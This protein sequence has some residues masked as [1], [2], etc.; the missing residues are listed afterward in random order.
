VQNARQVLAFRNNV[1]DLVKQ[2]DPSQLLLQ[3]F[4]REL[5]LLHLLSQIQRAFLDALLQLGMGLLQSRILC[6]NLTQHVIEA[7]GK[8]AQL[9]VPVLQ[10]SQGIV[11]AGRDCSCGSRQL[12]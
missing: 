12:G 11:A 1:S 10:R 9:V 7:V 4:L 8:L 5:A 2:A 3:R 6:L